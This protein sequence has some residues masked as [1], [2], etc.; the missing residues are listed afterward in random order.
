MSGQD[1]R[2]RF[3]M[4]VGF[5][6]EYSQEVKM[7]KDHIKITTI[8]ARLHSRYDGSYLGDTK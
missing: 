7:I 5:C 6:L 8:H 2:A 4:L 1:A 3:N